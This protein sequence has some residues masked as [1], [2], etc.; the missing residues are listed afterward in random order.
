MKLREEED[1]KER[2]D[3]QLE[4]PWYQVGSGTKT[5]MVG[6]LDQTGRNEN[7]EE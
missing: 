4:V 3:L 5:Y 7:V 2:Q 1:E 6:L